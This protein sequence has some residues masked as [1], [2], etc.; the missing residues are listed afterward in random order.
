LGVLNKVT[1][2]LLDNGKRI[3]WGHIFLAITPSVGVEY[4]L[5]E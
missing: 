1:G 2:A 4:F 5:N 3:E